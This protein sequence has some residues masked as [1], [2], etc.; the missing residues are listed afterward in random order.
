[1]RRSKW[2]FD[3]PEAT[4][5]VAGFTAHS[6]SCSNTSKR[7]H[8]N[9]GATDRCHSAALPRPRTCR[10]TRH[11]SSVSATRHVLQGDTS[12]GQYRM[13]HIVAKAGSVGM[14]F[15]LGALIAS[16]R[17][18]VN[19]PGRQVWTEGVSTARSILPT[20]HASSVAWTAGGPCRVGLHEPCP[21]VLLVH[22]VASISARPSPR[23]H[24]CGAVLR[25]CVTS[26]EVS[27]A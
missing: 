10:R 1:M 17:A 16:Y 24:Q 19:R 22:D 3:L 7:V 27:G 26:W 12:T 25:R 20:L 15:L 21:H 4:A 8:I 2:T 13:G 23:R 14:S 18:L 11:I 5:C 6:P 9:K